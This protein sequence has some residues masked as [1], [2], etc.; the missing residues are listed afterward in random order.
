MFLINNSNVNTEQ[1]IFVE[2]V[3]QRLINDFDW[4]LDDTGMH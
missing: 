2:W 3:T 4:D 1:P